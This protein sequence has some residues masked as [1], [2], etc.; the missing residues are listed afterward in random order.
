MPVRQFAK[1]A[2]LIACLSTAT[3]AGPTKPTRHEAAATEADKA[4]KRKLYGACTQCEPT[5]GSEEYSGIPQ[6]TASAPLPANLDARR[7]A[8]I[9]QAAAGIGKVVEC[10]DPSKPKQRLG[11]DFLAQVFRKSL[12]DSTHDK[13]AAQTSHGPTDWCGLYAVASAINAGVDTKWGTEARPTWISHTQPKPGAKELQYAHPVKLPRIAGS[14]GIQPGDI[15]QIEHNQH[16]AVVERV[17]DTSIFTID[18]NMKCGGIYRNAR[19]RKLV[20]GYYRTVP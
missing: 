1:V 12:G 9:Q 2:A 7:R 8:I 16:L 18:G 15:M 4:L 13:E 10:A 3:V 17:T 11:A 19:A 6:K 14:A 20:K 5:W